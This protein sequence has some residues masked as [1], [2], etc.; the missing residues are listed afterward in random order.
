MNLPLLKSLSEAP[1]GV[2][3]REGRAY[4]GGARGALRGHGEHDQVERGVDL[5]KTVADLE[6]YRTEGHEGELAA[7]LRTG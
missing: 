2:G 6:R 7:L 1:G 5:V 3:Q 4:R